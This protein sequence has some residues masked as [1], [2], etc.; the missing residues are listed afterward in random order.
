MSFRSTT[1]QLAQNHCP[2]AIDHFESGM[3]YDRS[4]FATGTAAHA[5]LEAAA[6]GV[7]E[8]AMD[9]CERRLLTV[10]RYFEAELE[11]PLPPEAVKAGR[12]L[13]EQWLERNPV[14]EG[15]IAEGTIAVDRDWKLVTP[16]SERAYYKAALDLRYPLLVEDEE[17]SYHVAVAR[18]GDSCL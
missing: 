6:K 9:D 8:F 18:L 3:A 11:P 17:Q 15:A 16:E 13:A 7:T 1:L 2:R 12:A 14:P 5:F 10:G 4:I